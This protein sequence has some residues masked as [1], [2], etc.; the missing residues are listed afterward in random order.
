MYGDKFGDVF[1]AAVD[2]EAPPV[3][4]HSHY[5]AIIT[6]LCVDSHDRCAAAAVPP[7]AACI[8]HFETRLCHHA[9]ACTLDCIRPSEMC[10]LL[11]SGDRDG[12]VKVCVLPPPGEGAWQVVSFCL[13]HEGSVIAAVFLPHASGD[14]LL[15]AGLDG[16]LI[17][18][19][20]ASGGERAR[21][22]VASGA[23]AAYKF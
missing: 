5:C 23:L 10:R 3:H 14:V 2:G 11:A 12:K 7:S 8:V 1:A 20:A 22:T 21:L 17:A 16:R 15:S 18:W 19:D 9:P 4:L 13:G 6:A